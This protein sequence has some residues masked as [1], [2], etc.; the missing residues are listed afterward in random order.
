MNFQGQIGKSVEFSYHNATGRYF[1]RHTQPPL[2]DM[3]QKEIKESFESLPINTDFDNE[4]SDF[5][6]EPPF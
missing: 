3:T 6:N 4:F 5:L 2:F 1:A